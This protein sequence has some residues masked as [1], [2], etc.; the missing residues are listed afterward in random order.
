[1]HSWTLLVASLVM[2]GCIATLLGAVWLFNRR[3][4]GLWSWALSYVCATFAVLNYLFRLELPV[5]LGNMGMALFTLGTASFC[6][7][8]ARSF[9]GLPVWSSRRLLILGVGLVTAVLLFEALEPPRQLRFGLV[10]LI[11]GAIYLYT[12]WSMSRNPRHQLPVRHLFA[13]ACGLHGLFMV[14]RPLLFVGQMQQALDYQ[15]MLDAAQW[16]VLETM[17]AL[18]AIA[19]TVLMLVNEHLNAELRAMAQRDSLTGTFNRRTFMTLL[20][21]AAS[22]ARRRQTVVP[23]LVM[24]IDHFKAINDRHGHRY[25]DMALQHFVNIAQR[26]L[27]KEDVLGRLGGEEFGAFLPNTLL[28]DAHDVAERL[29]QAVAANPLT[30]NTGVIRLT[31]S[32]GVAHFGAGDDLEATIDRA[33]QAMYKAKQ[34]GRNQV[35]LDRSE[36]LKRAIA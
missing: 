31:V 1:M 10:S 29:R 14:G 28:D 27:R 24:D 13:W 32:I 22:S 6:L 16:V 21:K 26:T 11:G 2:S 25:G 5:L 19:F 4:P 35:V 7:V 3:V 23:L 17:V 30:T 33:D 9:Q 8:G 18:L 36:L 12:G 15:V 20:D 34:A